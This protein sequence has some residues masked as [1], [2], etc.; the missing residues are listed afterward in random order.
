VHDVCSTG[1]AKLNAAYLGAVQRWSEGAVQCFYIHLFVDR[2]KSLWSFLF[3]LAGMHAVLFYS[4]YAKVWPNFWCCQSPAPGEEVWCLRRLVDNPF[5]AGSINPVEYLT[6]PTQQVCD[7]YLDSYKS[8]AQSSWDKEP[9]LASLPDIIQILDFCWWWLALLTV[10]FVAL[11]ICG[12]TSKLPGLVRT[13]IMWDNCSYWLTSWTLFVWVGLSAYMLILNKTPFTFDVTTFCL[14]TLTLKSF[15]Y[16]MQ[17][18]MK[19]A[20]NCDEMSIWR[21]QQM[22]FV[23]S[24]L[25]ILS[26]L[27]G[28][29]AAYGIWKH[30]IDKSFW[31]ATDHGQEVI[32][33]VKCWTAFIIGSFVSSVVIVVIA[34]FFTSIQLAQIIALLLFFVMVLTVWTPVLNI[35]GGTTQ[36]TQWRQDSIK[37]VN[38]STLLKW[39]RK[40]MAKFMLWG[41]SK[42][43]ML[44]WCTDLGLPL[45]LLIFQGLDSKFILFTAYAQTS[46][47]R[48]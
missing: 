2:C 18:R 33:L 36:L 35:W 26:F 13:V 42:S 4:L 43:Y 8:Y 31:S 24:P 47:L 29:S 14:F 32:N 17:Q 38:C 23:A 15:A 44:R 28:T 37:V 40:N 6:W 20:G 21:S 25:H 3:F 46:V 30:N 39:C 9:W 45:M 34:S 5:A 48:L 1:I 12:F 41:R 27:Q 16:I 10:L 11:L 22:F 19:F 7:A